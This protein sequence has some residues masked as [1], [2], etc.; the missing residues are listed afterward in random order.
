MAKGWIFVDK[1]ESVPDSFE[2]KNFYISDNFTIKLTFFERM[3]LLFGALIFGK[4]SYTVQV[5]TNSPET[6]DLDLLVF[7]KKSAK[8][9]TTASFKE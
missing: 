2:L 5:L 1:L 7:K 3:K 6:I 8:I 9:E 4:F